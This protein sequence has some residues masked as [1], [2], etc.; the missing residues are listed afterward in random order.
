MSEKYKFTDLTGQRFGRLTVLKLIPMEE[1]TWSNKEKAYECLCDCGNKTIVRQRN[2]LST[3]M[4]RSCGCLRKIEAFKKTNSIKDLPEE[5]LYSFK[6]FEKF[7]LIHRLL[8]SNDISMIGLSKEKYMDYMNYFYYQSQFN[9]VYN[10]WKKEEKLN[11]FYDWAK[12]SLDHIIP[13]SKG[14]NNEKEN[15][16][17][18]T[19]FE[20]LA[21]RDM[22]MK[23]WNNFKIKTNTHSQYFIEEIMKGG[24]ANE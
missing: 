16:Q 14:G 2:L 4:T 8:R 19:T 7:L 10:F 5:W 21:K 6:D 24:D 13:K 15:L 12:P 1:R 20:N 11:T 22:T 3:S 17:F 9:K 18:I 23:E